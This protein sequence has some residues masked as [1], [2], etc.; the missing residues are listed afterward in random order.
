MDSPPE[1]RPRLDEEGRARKSSEFRQ[2]RIKRTDSHFL[3]RFGSR[4]HEEPHRR[5]IRPVRAHRGDRSRVSV[6]GK[7]LSNWSM[8]Q[9]SA[10]KT[11]AVGRGRL[12][13][14]TC[15]AETTKS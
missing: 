8:V 9:G 5:A 3:T 10:L 13:R 11:V 6:W 14:E 12:I 15:S 4:C 1:Y 2:Y 7:I